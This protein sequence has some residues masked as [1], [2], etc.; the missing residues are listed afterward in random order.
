MVIKAASLA[1]MRVP[2]TNSSWQGE[3]I[4]EYKS[5]DM[6]V[7]VQ[8]PIGL[9]TPIIKNSD[10]KGLEHISQE[11]KDL[12]ARAKEGKLQPSE[13][14]GGTFTISNMGMFGVNGFSPIVNPPQAC[15]I[16]VGSA[17]KKV[18]PGEGDQF[19]VANVMNVTLSSDHR[20]VD[21]ALAAE[22]TQHFRRFIEIPELMLL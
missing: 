5:V 20:V 17:L 16:G 6:S 2:A 18:L 12:A 1:A 14:I 4:R 10:T 22:W 11:M 7:A 8:T 19:R 21:G 13:F 9:L 15:I 3:F